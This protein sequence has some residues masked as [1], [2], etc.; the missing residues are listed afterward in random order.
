M[1]L[2]KLNS[3][4]IAGCSGDSGGPVWLPDDNM[5]VAVEGGSN[6][7]NIR[8]FEPLCSASSSFA[9]KITKEILDWI[10]KYM[11]K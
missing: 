11:K 6:V 7:E 4:C 5:I 2:L 8:W 3:V 10:E 1:Q 9:T